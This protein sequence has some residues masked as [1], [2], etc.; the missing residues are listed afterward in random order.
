MMN[1]ASR[2]NYR[3]Q[4]GDQLSI[5]RE[6]NLITVTGAG[7]KYFENTYESV[8]NTPYV[9]G[10]RARYYV[11]EYALGFNRDAARK[12]TYV[13]YPNGKVDRTYNLGLFKV[14]P[15]IQK[16]ATIYTAVVQEKQREK[17]EKREVK[18]LDWNQA[19]ATVTSAIMG[20]STVYVLL[21]R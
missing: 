18:P 15:K 9:P 17:R 6:E 20:F 19:V 21:T 7:H 11:K 3:L 16:G 14:Y 2:Y 10:K 13:K 4:P 12:D 1:S 8:V 5:P